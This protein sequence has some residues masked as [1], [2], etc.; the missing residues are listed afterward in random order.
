ME[1]YFRDG[2]LVGLSGGADSVML[3]YFLLEYRARHSDFNIV[4][5]HVNHMI[6]AEEADR[7]ERF[8]REIALALGVEFISVSVDVPAIAKDAQVGLEEAARNARYSEFDKIILG[9]KDISAIAVAHNASDNLETVIFNIMRGAGARGA[10]GI[11]PVRDNIVR[12]LIEIAKSD[13]CKALADAE[14]PYVTDSTNLSCDYTRNFIR[15]NVIESMRE[16]F[17]APERAASRLSRALRRDDEYI[18]SVAEDFL[19]SNH[20]VKADAL[21]SLHEAVFARVIKLMVKDMSRS[22]EEVHISNIRKLLSSGDFSLSLPGGV[23]F[24]SERGVCSAFFASNKRDLDYSY[25]ISLGKN[26]ISE[27]GAEIFLNTDKKQEFSLNV[28][29]NSIHADISS[30]IISGDL[31]LRPK[32]DGDTVFYGG[33]THKLK[34]VFCDLKIPRTLRSLIP[35][36]CDDRGVVWVPG[37]AVRDDGVPA[38]ERTPLFV[39]MYFDDGTLPSDKRMHAISEFRIKSVRAENNK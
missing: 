28:Y 21:L 37:L 20:T 39:S 27:Y 9:R 23:T 38:C 29:K 22:V 35:V 26:D 5:C 12:P 18:N 16:H 11:A 3:L 15:N 4:A 13:I 10:A 14:I 32:K 34:K 17:T 19:S 2:V 36:L 1:R 24:I 25:K 7:D 31:Y 33:H 30:A 8:S 6:R